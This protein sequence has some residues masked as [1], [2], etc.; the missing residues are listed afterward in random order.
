VYVSAAGLRRLTSSA[1]VP[2]PLDP[3]SVVP[4]NTQ[5]SMSEPALTSASNSENRA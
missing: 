4:R 2:L 3:T 1:D 5:R